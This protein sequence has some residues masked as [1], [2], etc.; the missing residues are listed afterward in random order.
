[1][2]AGAPGRWSMLPNGFAL[3][4]IVCPTVGELID[5][6]AWE[7]RTIKLYGRECKVPRLTAWM[8]TEAYT[9]SGIRHESCVFPAAV[10]ETK[11]RIEAA[12]GMRFNSVLANLYRSGSDSVA[13][14]S[15]DEP[16]LGDEPVIA[17]VSIGAPRV[18]V[19]RRK[20]TGERTKINLFHGDLLVMSGRSQLDYMHAVP[21]LRFDPGQRINLT[22]RSVG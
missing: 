6:I 15:D 16:E 13:E 14:H 10:A 11:S 18:F 5:A 4:R 7:Q 8:G 9:Y 3:S 21:K 20:E 2:I 17:S 1:M 12:T 19:I 22:F